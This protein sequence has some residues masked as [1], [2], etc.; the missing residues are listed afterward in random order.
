MRI[1]CILF[2]Y[3]NWVSYLASR[4]VGVLADFVPPTLSLH[5]S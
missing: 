3:K 4:L 1:S 2:L 5:T